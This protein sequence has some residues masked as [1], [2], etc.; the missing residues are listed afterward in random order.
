VLLGALAAPLAFALVLEF[1]T[2]VEVGPLVIGLLGPCER[3]G[4]CSAMLA[5]SCF[6]MPRPVRGDE[7]LAAL[8]V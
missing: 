4:A 5:R 6:E 1:D 2:A 8:D 3:S 7:S